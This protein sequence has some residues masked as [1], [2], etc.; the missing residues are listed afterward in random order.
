MNENN[1]LVILA[2]GAGSRF[3]PISSEELP[4]QFLDILGCGRTLIQLTLERF[5]G[6]IP[7]ENVWVVT[8]EKYREIVMEQLPEIPSSNILCEPCRRNTAPCICYVSWKIKKLN[9][10]AN[11]V[12]SPSD[13][14]VVDIQ[15]FQSAID[16]SLSFA[17]ETDAVVTLGLKPTRPETGY[18]YIKADLTYSSSR[19]H[20]IFRVDEFKEKPTLEIAKEYIQSP[21]YLWN[22]GIF[23]WNINTIINAFRV[24]EPEVSSIFEGLMPYYDTDEEQNKIDESY[25]QCKNI[26]VDYAILEKAEEIFVFPASFSWS[27]LGTWNSL[28][29]QSDMDKYG[30][31]CIG[32]NIKLYDTYNTI[33]HTCNKKEVIVEGL[34]GYVV[35]EKEGKLLVCRLSEEQRIKLFH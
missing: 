23:I 28:R 5:N 32:D 15:A 25:P 34:D 19:K 17:A 13:H 27:D 21:N 6:L 33:V 10:K 20:N 2:G 11:I 7:K 18:G 14:L 29:E 26:S 1:Y 30:N 4:K 31:V 16:D 8:A 22:S 24:Y 9:T 12:V 3:W 35:A